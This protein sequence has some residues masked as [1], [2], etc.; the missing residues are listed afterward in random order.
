[1]GEGN[2]IVS[3][4]DEN[5]IREEGNKINRVRYIEDSIRCN[6]YVNEKRF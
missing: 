2:S 3:E 4:K 1:M 5:S 6:G